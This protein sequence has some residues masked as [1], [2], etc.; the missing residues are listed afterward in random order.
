MYLQNHPLN[1]GTFDDGEYEKLKEK[2]TQTGLTVS[3]F[4]FTFPAGD[5]GVAVFGDYAD[6]ED[7]TVI[8]YN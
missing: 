5:P 3:S 4:A 6:L 2:E 1:K 7:I 8:A